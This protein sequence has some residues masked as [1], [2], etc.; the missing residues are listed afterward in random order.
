MKIRLPAIHGYST[1]ARKITPGLYIGDYGRIDANRFTGMEAEFLM[2]A[3]GS[4]KHLFIYQDEALFDHSGRWAQS[5]GDFIFTGL[6]VSE[7]HQGVF[8]VFNPMEDDTNSVRDVTDSGFT[9]NEWTPLRQKPY[10]MAYKRKTDFPKLSQGAYY[11]HVLDTSIIVADTSDTTGAVDTLKV[12][13]K[14]YRFEF[15]GGDT[16]RFSMTVDSLETYQLEAQ[17]HQFGS[18]LVT[19]NHRDRE[20]DTANVFSNWQPKEGT[21]FMKLKEAS[22]TAILLQT[23]AFS[24]EPYGFL[25]YSKNGK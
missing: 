24:P 20:R 23:P 7:S 4:F 18:F 5:G 13:D 25:P 12:V 6:T 14:L 1:A 10:W 8:D 17:Y 19:E 3:D 16:L 11:H 21:I 22:E 9:R 15:G 2:D